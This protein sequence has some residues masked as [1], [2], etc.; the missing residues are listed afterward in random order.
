[1]KKNKLMEKIQILED[2]E[3]V[4]LEENDTLRL[5]VETLKNI[6][7]DVTEKRFRTIQRTVS[8]LHEEIK[9]KDRYISKL[10]E[11]ETESTLDDVVESIEKT[12]E[13]LGRVERAIADASYQDVIVEKD[14]K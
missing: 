8:K 5:L 9:E 4:L 11:A 10:K 14:N 2:C 1:M 6:K 12:N 13:R 3:H 7:A